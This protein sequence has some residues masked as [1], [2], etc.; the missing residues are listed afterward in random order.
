MPTDREQLEQE[1]HEQMET[2]IRKMLD[3]LPEATEI[4]LSDMEKAVGEMGQRIMEATLQRLIKT[5]QEPL[6]ET[7]PC[8]TCGEGMY[9]R[10]KR[11]R[12]VVTTRGE[13]EIE[14]Q[15]YIC[16]KCGTR[17]FPPG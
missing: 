9:R 14:R 13:V 5:Q 11:R 7:V 15:Y 1:L 17:H 8:S 4:T 3:G 12:R 16:P 10:G 6:P 2:A